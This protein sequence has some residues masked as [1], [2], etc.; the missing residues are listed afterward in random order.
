MVLAVSRKSV[1]VCAYVLVGVDMHDISGLEGDDGID[2][3]D[4]RG[5]FPDRVR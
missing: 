4:D 5:A 3:A 1:C 2:A